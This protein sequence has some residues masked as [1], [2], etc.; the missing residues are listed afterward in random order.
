MT[1]EA[2]SH[3]AEHAERYVCEWMAALVLTGLPITPESLARLPSLTHKERVGDRDNL[4]VSDEEDFPFDVWPKVARAR[5]NSA[6]GMTRKAFRDR[7]IEILA[8]LDIGE[9]VESVAA[10]FR[11]TA[12]RVM[13]ISRDRYRWTS[14]NQQI[15]T[16]E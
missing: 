14:T 1:T 5:V 12:Q 15:R 10:R 13:Q 2:I 11:V 16:I 7:N 4:F 3:E 6:R 9:S 8:L